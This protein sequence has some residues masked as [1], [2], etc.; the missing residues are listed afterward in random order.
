M[1]FLQ[2]LFYLFSIVVVATFICC[3]D[4]TEDFSTS[5][6][7]ILTFSH[8]TLTFDTVFSKIGSTTKTLM[9]Y[10]PNN[11]PLQISSIELTSGGQTGFRINVDGFSGTSFK[12]VEIQAKDSMYVFVEVTLD[13]N[14]TD[15]PMLMED[16]ITFVTNT[17]IQKVTLEAYG[18]DAYIWKGKI[19]EES[20]S[21]TAEKPY[22][23]YD[24]LFVKEG[25]TLQ[26]EEGTRI[27]MHDKAEI[28]ISGSLKI[29]GTLQNPVTIRGD[30]LDNMFTDL[31]YDKN[32]GQWDGIYFSKTS[33]ENEIDYA[34]I[35]NGIYGLYFEESQPDQ[36]KLI[37]KNTV[38]TNTNG[39][40]FTAINCNIQGEN[41]E[42]SNAG[43]ALLALNG[44]KY[45]FIQCTL[46]NY[47]AWDIHT[48][49][50]LTL[51]NSKKDKDNNTV[52]LPLSQADFLNCIIYGSGNGKSE[53]GLY[54]VNQST[55]PE[56]TFNYKIDYSLIKV[57]QDSIN[58][59][60]VTNCILNKDPKFKTIDNK[61]LTYDFRLD[62][63]SPAINVAS[64][65]I[66]SQVP[67]DMNGISRFLDEGPDMGAYEWISDK[68]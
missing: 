67:Y 63:I 31:P 6:S 24:S 15:N 11:K 55:Y 35:R 36:S 30:R 16:E 10:N 46:A 52:I 56:A 25:I 34:H 17:V 41:C 4:K 7:D 5:P 39:N 8:D 47:F 40:L 60:F 42:F 58:T 14:N 12:Q 49:R 51:R 68:K 23:I 22:L 43:G 18:Q 28:I 3:T 20:T 19:I 53:I 21:L 1:H 29:K 48:S 2:K 37:I 62:S 54:P 64:P 33:F 26:M 38:L 61:T 27:Y 45:Q 66:A 65:T 44:G 13:P 32:P 9:V 50:S 59:N 57:N